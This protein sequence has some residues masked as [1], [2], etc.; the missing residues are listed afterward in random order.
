MPNTNNADEVSARLGIREEV[1]FM[2]LSE[3]RRII[4]RM[5]KEERES[6][7]RWNGID[8]RLWGLKLNL[9]HSNGGG[10]V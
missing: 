2:A 5:D 10:T 1:E 7:G 8:G 4:H 9:R 6:G 3:S